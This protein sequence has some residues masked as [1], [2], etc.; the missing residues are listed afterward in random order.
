MGQISAVAGHHRRQHHSVVLA[1]AKRRGQSSHG[2]RQCQQPRRRRVLPPAHSAG[3]KPSRRLPQPLHA[4][5]R[6]RCRR[7]D[8][9]VQQIFRAAPDAGIVIGLRRQQANHRAHAFA[10]SERLHFVLGASSGQRTVSR[11]PPLTG[12]CASLSS[13]PLQPSPRASRSAATAPCWGSST[14]C[15]SLRAHRPRVHYGPFHSAQQSVRKRG[16]RG[17]GRRVRLHLS[18]PRAQQQPQHRQRQPR[19][20]LR[21]SAAATPH[22]TATSASAINTRL[23][24]SH[25]RLANNNPCGKQPRRMKQRHG[26][27]AGRGLRGVGESPIAWGPKLKSEFGI[28]PIRNREFRHPCSAEARHRRNRDHRLQMKRLR[29]EIRQRDVLDRIAPPTARAG[30]GPVL[31]GRTTHT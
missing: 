26:G 12:A 23:G 24:R 6:N 28:K 27:Q 30:R 7:R 3:Q 25:I 8:S 13:S 10:A 1:Q 21:A 19:N 4:I 20:P 17:S 22:S 16:Q 14:F 18:A 9:L 31:P 2:R 29:K 5:N 15:S 11:T